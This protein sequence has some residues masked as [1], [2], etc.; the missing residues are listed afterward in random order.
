MPH[1]M[2]LRFA[3][4]LVLLMVAPLMTACS[5][6]TY[7]YHSTI[8]KPTTITLYDPMAQ[9]SLWTK[10]IPVG[11]SLKMD[12]D[13]K[14]EG[15]LMELIKMQKGMPA[16]VMRWKLYK[17]TGWNNTVDSDTLKLPGTPVRIDVSY[18]PAPEYPPGTGS[19]SSS[20]P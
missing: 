5:T 12:L 2:T 11:Q 7:Y 3:P 10:D 6:D 20:K 4:M 17:T 19:T 8:D 1:I 9:E 16:T 14:G 13:R 18:R 15:S